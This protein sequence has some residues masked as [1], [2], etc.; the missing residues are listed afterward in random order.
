MQNNVS[1]TGA[2]Q[3]LFLSMIEW[4]F[5]NCTTMPRCRLP[6][7]GYLIWEGYNSYDMAAGDSVIG[8]DAERARRRPGK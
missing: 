1:K 2:A 5:C 4:F 7:L 3:R 6:L 8:G